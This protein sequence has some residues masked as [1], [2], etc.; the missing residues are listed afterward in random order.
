MIGRKRRRLR[1][2]TVPTCRE[3]GRLLQAHLDGE[4]QLWEASAV[5]DH[6]NDCEGCGME[7][8]VYAEIKSALRRQAE[9]IPPEAT[10]RLLVFSERLAAGGDA[11]ASEL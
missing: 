3:V 1:N 11:P 4:L 9:E 6:L 7:A 5:A 2:G 10:A 8:E